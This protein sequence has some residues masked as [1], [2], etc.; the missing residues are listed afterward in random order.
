MANTDT[1]E[2][3]QQ[4]RAA[5]IPII[6]VSLPDAENPSTWVIDYAPTATPAERDAGQAL[7]AAYTSPTPNTLLDR[8]AEQRISEQA[9]IATATALW[10]C[11]PAPTMTKVQLRARA[12][13]IFK[14]L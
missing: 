4:L 13:A 8:F 3:D 2:L 12:K 10:E 6:G 7:L 5:N 1:T 9:L 14:T 11:I